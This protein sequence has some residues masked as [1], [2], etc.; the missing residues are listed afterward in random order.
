MVSALTM[1]FFSTGI[2]INKHNK[3]NLGAVISEVKSQ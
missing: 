1:L 3:E 2:E